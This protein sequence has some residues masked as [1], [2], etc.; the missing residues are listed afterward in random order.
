MPKIVAYVH[1]YVPKHN[2]G[3]E[4]TLHDMLKHLVSEGWE[5]TVVIKPAL[6]S[7]TRNRVEHELAPYV[8][9]G[10]EVVPGI[11]KRTLLH[12]VPKADITISHLECS[13]RTHLLSEAYKI[14]SIHLVHN[15]HPLTVR[16]MQS[17]SG[18]ILN[19]EWIANEEPFASWN[20]PKMV[21][22]PPVDPGEYKTTRGKSVTL[23][24]LW[25]DKGSAVF[26][27]LARRFPNTP[28]LGVKGGYGEQELVSLPNVTIMEHTSD[29]KKV[30][31][32]TKV[33]LMPSKY[34]SFGRVGVEAMASG[35]PTIAHPT[36]GLQESLG[37][38]GTFVDRV[39]L[40][41]WEKSLRE[42]LKPAR[43]GKVSKLAKARSEA[44]EKQRN[45]QLEILPM[46]L[47]EVIRSKTGKAV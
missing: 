31:G 28:F 26:Y 12:H 13:E 7:F 30:Y 46:F 6:V 9:D 24:N 3:A 17:S 34:E 10:V 1:A 2:A 25:E 11:D 18:L 33:I 37:D 27:E 29:M 16:W 42:L 41:G 36:P 32:E 21:I 5:A 39:D 22:N 45:Q 15:T 8:I 19:T 23:V 38:S 14:P 35:I 43:Y 40:D 44:L 47:K 20:A 4:T